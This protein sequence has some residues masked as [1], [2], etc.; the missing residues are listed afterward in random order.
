MKVVDMKFITHYQELIILNEM[1]EHDQ[2]LH[3]SLMAA[4]EE[5]NSLKS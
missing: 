2:K 3:E 5:E 1:E 4:R